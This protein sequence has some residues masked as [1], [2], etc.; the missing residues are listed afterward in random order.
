MSDKNR[1]IYIEAASYK[2]SEGVN[3]G[4]STCLV[5]SSVQT[6]EAITSSTTGKKAK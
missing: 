2:A 4:V 3:S 1:K 6:V 5:N